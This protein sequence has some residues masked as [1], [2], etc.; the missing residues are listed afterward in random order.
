MRLN[1]FLARAGVASRR[2]ADEL[3]K[4]GRVTDNGAPGQ[5]NSVVGAQ[6]RVEVDGEEV[7]RQRL[8]HRRPPLRVARGGDDSGGL[9]EQDVAKPLAFHLPAV[10]LDPVA[11][12]DDR[13][14][15]PR[16]AVDRDAAGLDQ[17][18]RAAAGRDACARQPGVQP[19]RRR[20]GR[21]PTG[22]PSSRP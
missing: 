9:V 6:D 11:R 5:L 20:A 21:R 13:V 19:N 1:A 17:L 18:V 16:L 15:L 22:F 7:E 12:A 10:H 8:E 14:Q 2:Q 3:I 4:A